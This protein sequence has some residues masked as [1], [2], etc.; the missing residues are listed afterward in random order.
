MG[1][2]ALSLVFLITGS[3]W[4]QVKEPVLEWSGSGKWPSGSSLIQTIDAPEPSWL[5]HHLPT[6]G[7]HSIRLVPF[8]QGPAITLFHAR[9]VQNQY[10]PQRM[11]W[12]DFLSGR[13]P[14]GAIKSYSPSRELLLVH[15]FYFDQP[16]E[17]H[18]IYSQKIPGFYQ[19]GELYL[20][21]GNAGPG[22]VHLSEDQSG[23]Q[24]VLCDTN[25]EVQETDRWNLPENMKRVEP[26]FWIQPDSLRICMVSQITADFGRNREAYR[27]RYET[28]F[29]LHTFWLD[30]RSGAV[31]TDTLNIPGYR[32]TQVWAQ[33]PQL[34]T[35]TGEPIKSEE[36]GICI[37][38]KPLK[39]V[40]EDKGLI[41]VTNSRRPESHEMRSLL[42]PEE[43]VQEAQFYVSGLRYD[44]KLEEI[45]LIGSYRHQGEICH[46]DFRSA[47]MVC[48]GY[49]F[50]HDVQIF[51]FGPDG[52]LRWSLQ[53]PRRQF[54]QQPTRL[55][56]AGELIWE[57]GDT[58]WVLWNDDARNEPGE[59]PKWMFTDP[60]RAGLRYV[61]V[62]QG[63]IAGNGLFKYGK[64]APT[65][66]TSYPLYAD[67]VL[68][69]TGLGQRKIFG[70][71]IRI[72]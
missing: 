32:V 8:S 31:E 59:K 12:L 52:R 4:S 21:P 50:V 69:V 71:K 72:R 34:L 20:F 13:R 11:A 37:F 14:V 66:F 43:A 70:G 44:R 61:A 36:N 57:K 29:L 23:L 58:I 33:S 6:F 35:L 15:L 28:V 67:S 22:L 45:T 5:I 62:N 10:G 30:R 53:I 38:F 47:R 1:R 64:K 42:V 51:R 54:V 65:L 48:T 17:K 16:E 25:L 46:T 7:Y 19:K 60:Q 2:S 3:L 63:G 56:A 26:L 41:Y 55:E 40:E 68:W 39:K 24:I 49:M 27:K 18:Q 9:P